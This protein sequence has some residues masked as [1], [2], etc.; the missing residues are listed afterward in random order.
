MMDIQQVIREQVTG[1]PI[2]LYM[3][4]TPQ[5]PQCGFSGTAI[6]ILKACGVQEILTVDVLTSCEK[7]IKTANCKNF[8]KR[9]LN[10]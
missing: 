1:H 7:C 5:F 4:G 3:K 9:P 2:V 8:W 6:Q 10:A